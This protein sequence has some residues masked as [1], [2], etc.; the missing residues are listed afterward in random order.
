MQRKSWKIFADSTE[1]LR[2]PLEKPEFSKFV[3]KNEFLGQ[4][5]M[6]KFNAKN[7]EMPAQ[8]KA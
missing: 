4:S 8:K 5:L 6:E 1:V 7:V 2:F 3:F